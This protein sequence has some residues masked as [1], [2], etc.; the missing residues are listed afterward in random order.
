V[1]D[2]RYLSTSSLVKAWW[3][4][5]LAAIVLIGWPDPPKKAVVPAT[6]WLASGAFVA[7]GPDRLQLP[8][9]LIDSPQAR[10]WTTWTPTAGAQ[11]GRLESPVFVLPPLGIAVPVRGAA[12]EAGVHAYV[13]CLATNE[14]LGFA[15]ARTNT[16]WAIATFSPASSWCAGDRRVRLVADVAST[17][18]ELSLGTPFALTRSYL[19]KTSTLVAASYQF[20]AWSVMAGLAWFCWTALG[21]RFAPAVRAGL[22]LASL[23]LV[24]YA[25]FFV[26]YAAASLG[27]LLSVGLWALGLWQA[28]KLVAARADR[29]TVDGQFS[30][31]LV[32]WLAVALM[33]LAIHG[34]VDANAGS[35][36]PNARFSPARWSSDNQLPMRIGQM[37]AQGEIGNTGWMGP[38]K[39][40]DR[41]PLAYGWHALMTKLFGSHLLPADGNYLY[42]RYSWPTGILLNTLWAPLVYALMRRWFGSARLA[43]AMVAA[44]LM[45]P[46]L[47]FNSGYIWP[48]L[49]AGAFGLGAAA[50]LFD[51]A[52]PV[53]RPL[54][55]DTAGFVTA[56][57]LSA[58]ALQAHGGAM[59]ALPPMIA[60]ALWLRGWP[61]LRALLLSAAVCLAVLAPWMLY[62][63]WVDPPGNALVKFAFA[64]TFGFGEEQMGVLATIRRAYSALTPESWLALKA[65]ALGVLLSGQ[66]NQCGVGE[67][68]AT[69]S[70]VDVWRERDF[71]YVVPS[72]TLLI[73]AAVAARLLPRTRD[74]PPAGSWLA[75]G[76]LS[77]AFST[78]LTLDCHLNHHQ[79]YQALLALHMGLLLVAA[80][81]VRFFRVAWV[82]VV[83][84]G[85]LVWV[86]E[87]LRHYDRW[88][89]SALLVAG[90]AALAVTWVLG[91][92]DV[93]SP[94]P[95][96]R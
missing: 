60:I 21:Q 66:G 18:H 49:L 29:G 82:G 20:L 83:G 9:S 46:L 58:L 54:G 73:A 23:G 24:G 7:T 81:N 51:A 37:L 31:A 41:P 4:A 3:V 62:Q 27:A 17:T 10:F 25:M 95:T 63:H 77:V 71:Y 72:L 59:F 42:A 52:S 50:L 89:Q 84:Y 65:R 61:T 57:L 43:V 94:E 86:L 8:G 88:D 28:G 30:A 14:A 16:D 36:S 15:G 40:S 34:L 47:L 64:G 44:C 35:W 22:A 33:V 13:A 85:L 32:L 79:S 74:I 67:L 69:L 39:V 5:L 91:R 75:W 26:F 55:Q 96:T 1:T 53:R 19:L 2:R 76:V 92:E 6:G 45:S 87:P 70:A 68:G 38:W 48:K 90:L 78:V 56:A 12:G 80:R 93:V 11:P